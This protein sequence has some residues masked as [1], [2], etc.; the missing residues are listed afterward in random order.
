M[1]FCKRLKGKYQLKEAIIMHNTILRT[2][3]WFLCIFSCLILTL[4]NGCAKTTIREKSSNGVRELFASPPTEY[5]SAPLWVWNDMITEEQVISTMNDLASQKVKQVFVHPRPGLMTPYLSDAWFRLWKTALKEAKKLDMNVW[6]YDEN[7]YPSGFAGGLV[8]EAMPEARGCG[9]AA[10]EHKK[11]PIHS[12]ETVAVYQLVK[13]KYINITNKASSNEPLPDGD[14][15]EIVIQYAQPGRWFGGKY[16][17]D[18]LKPGVTEKF[19]EITMGAYQRQIGDY[20]GGRVPGVFTDEPHLAP[21]GGLHWTDDLEEEFHKRWG[22]SLMDH[23][24]SLFLPVGDFKKVRH[25]YYQVLLDMFID[26][27]ARPFYEYC[28]E[29]NLEFTGHYWEHDWPNV[30]CGSDNMAMYAWHQRPAIDILMNQYSEKVHAQFGNVRAVKELS[31]AAN[32]LG[33]NRTLCEAYGAGGWDLRFEDMKRIGDWLF[34]LGVNTMDEHLSYITIRGARKR[35]HPQ[36][37]SYHE[38]WWKAYHIMAEYFSRLS[39]ALSQGREI[40]EILVIEPTSAAW[41]YQGMKEEQKRIGDGFQQLVTSMSKAQVEYDIGCEDIIARNGRIDGNRFVIG[42]RRYHTVV[43]SPFTENLNGK[44]MRLLEK[45]LQNEGKVLCCG[46]APLRLDGKESEYG[47]RLA[48]SSNWETVHAD[49]LAQRLAS[50]GQDGFRICRADG[51][52][53]ILFHQRRCFEDGQ[54]LFLVNTSIESPATGSIESACRGIEQWNPRTGQISS[55]PFSKVNSGIRTKFNLP[56]CGSLLLFLSNNAGK[57]SV[58]VEEKG[59]TIETNGTLAVRRTGPNV[60]T[61]DYVDVSAC[62]QTKEDIYFYRASQFIFQQNGMEHNPWDSAVQFRDE[63]I[64]KT[65]DK[66]S[67]FEAEYHFNI[68]QILPE[69]LWIVIER[70]DLYEITCNGKTVTAGKG[71]WW[72]DKSFGRIDIKDAVKLGENTVRIKAS[73]FTIYHE[74]EPAYLLGEF[75]L[76]QTAS[77]FIL[78]GGESGMKT[79]SWKEQGCPFYAE[80]MSYTQTFEINRPGGK[81][82]VDLEKWYGSVVEVKVNGKSAGYIGY[83]PWRCEVTDFIRPGVNR[84][85]VIVTGTLKNTLGPHHAGSGR[86]SAWPGMFQQGPENGPPAG[87]KYDTVDYGLFEPFTLEQITLE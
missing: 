71:M 17:V 19:L 41:M 77:G 73:P 70:T 27:W 6:I 65:F 33:R 59:K 66:S 82:F 50:S 18:L 25:N 7:S 36:S 43:I 23:L 39:A 85:E 75:A 86:G 49:Q 78:V 37:F 51:D 9:I 34:V 2:Y 16:Y 35:D 31:S 79:G 55:Y 63:F 56:P 53:G 60:L 48:G 64:R 80:G 72:L 47:A 54:L 15:L 68:E 32:Q 20:F 76:K 38:P 21:A 45:F 29:H 61:I 5:S 1:V 52:T 69:S 30:S 10:R 11:P 87:E 13:D 3:P 58:P 28:G 26:R 42:Q 14:Y 24:P 44:T 57:E 22:Y 62:G 46:Q 12:Y 81:Y 74:L 40:N 84:V 8:P 4:V 67:G 83:R